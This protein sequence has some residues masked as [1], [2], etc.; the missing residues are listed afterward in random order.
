MRSKPET[1]QPE[2]NID[3]N[4]QSRRTLVNTDEKN[5]YCTRQIDVMS[6]RSH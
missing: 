2:L 1:N 4:R 3:V 6:R 5:R